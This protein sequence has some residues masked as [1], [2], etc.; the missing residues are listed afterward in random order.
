MKLPGRVGPVVLL[1]EQHPCLIASRPIVG[2]LLESVGIQFMHQE[3]EL[4]GLP[5]PTRPL[6]GG[7]TN[8]AER[9]GRHIV[10]GVVIVDQPAIAS[11][12]FIEPAGR[13]IQFSDDPSGKQLVPV[14][15]DRL[16]GPLPRVF[17]LPMREGHRGQFGQHVRVATRD[18]RQHLRRLALLALSRQAP[19]QPDG[20][21][22]ILRSQRPVQ[23]C[24][25]GI[26]SAEQQ[27]PRLWLR[28]RLG[29]CRQGKDRHKQQTQNVAG[30]LRVP[31][32]SEITHKKPEKLQ[33]SGKKNGISRCFQHI[34][35]DR[36]HQSAPPLTEIAEQRTITLA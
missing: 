8:P 32:S 15:P 26:L 23:L 24:R 28:R 11:V 20:C 12:G 6:R 10:V 4:V 33:K 3:L 7:Q 34:S 18:A 9:F 36:S 35:I 17:H 14:E 5:I 2:L 22:R 29:R 25:L 27:L 19:S 30:T 16:L 1:Q 13:S 21:R 31:F